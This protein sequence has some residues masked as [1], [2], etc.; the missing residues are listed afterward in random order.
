MVK[1][2]VIGIISLVVMVLFL[3]PSALS[4]FESPG[5]DDNDLVLP[6]SADDTIL[7][8]GDSAFNSSNGI[9]SGSGILSDPYILQNRTIQVTDVN[10]IQILN[11]TAHLLIRNC[12]LIGPSSN[13]ISGISIQNGSNI[14]LHKV[15]ISNIYKG[16]FGLETSHIGIHETR[17][18]N[19]TKGMVFRRSNNVS[20]DRSILDQNGFGFFAQTVKDLYL[21]NSHLHNNNNHAIEFNVVTSAEIIGNLM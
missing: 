5:H 15:N 1:N 20:L 11:T 2:R 10:G 9:S 4:G 12:T 3:F 21:Q 8:E 18:D 16:L 14:T 13:L 7:I 17:V 19:C 6:S